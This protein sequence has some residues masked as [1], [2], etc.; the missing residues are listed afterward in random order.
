MLAARR[1]GAAGAVHSRHTKA[2]GCSAG[3]HAGFCHRSGFLPRA[4][5]WR[6]PRHLLELEDGRYLCRK[7]GHVVDPS[8]REVFDLQSCEELA[9]VVRGHA[10]RLLSVCTYLSL[11]TTCFAAQWV[12]DNWHMPFI[13]KEIEEL[14]SRLQ[15]LEGAAQVAAV[16]DAA[17][18]DVRGGVVQGG[19]CVALR[20]EREESRCDFR[21]LNHIRS[22]GINWSFGMGWAVTA[23]LLLCRPQVLRARQIACAWLGV[24]L[25]LSL[26]GTALACQA[27]QIPFDTAHAAL[28]LPPPPFTHFVDRNRHTLIYDLQ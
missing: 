12:D 25:P 26:V 9:N 14:S 27:N 8:T 4:I 21:R 15:L 20:Q 16:G 19:L 1:R 10:V 28:L 22:G 13:V 5:V 6:L 17:A 11:A 24:G 2:G 23:G 18:A 7:T 3:G